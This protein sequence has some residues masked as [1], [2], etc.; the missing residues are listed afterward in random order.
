M[1]IQNRLVSGISGIILTMG[2]LVSN[3][4]AQTS[5][6]SSKVTAK[7]ANLTLLPKTS[8]TADWQTVLANTIKT[9]NQ[10]DLFISASFEVG[11]F[12]QTLVS[13]KNLTKDTS[14]ADANVQVRVLLDGQVVEPGAVVYGRRTQ[15][16]SATLEGAI[17]SCL[18]VVTNLDGSLSVVVD[19]NC[20]TPET[21]ELILDSM[22]AAS[23]NF[24]AVDVPQGVHTVSVQARID[25]TGSAQ[26]G[27]Y[28][29]LGTIRK[30][31]MTVESVRL[32]KDPNVVLEVHY[33]GRYLAG[34]GSLRLQ[35]VRLVRRLPVP[36][37]APSPVCARLSDPG[38]PATLPKQLKH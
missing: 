8:G 31:T 37:P 9:A 12:T 29:P 38:K 32:I 34:I 13:S 24:V 21:I 15:T 17:G 3:G 35:F 11:L 23:F 16:L 27:S 33:R 4:H 22:D 10:K 28:S 6:P 30:G 20:V 5:Q 1:K 7:T 2:L 36:H 18:T 25:T 14:T 26:T 19:P